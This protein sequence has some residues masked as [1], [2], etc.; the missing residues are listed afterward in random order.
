MTASEKNRLVIRGLSN[1]EVEYLKRKSLS[2]NLS[3]NQ[4]MIDKIRLLID[5]ENFKSA[6]HLYQ[7]FLEEQVKVNEVLLEKFDER[8]KS[9]NDIIERLSKMSDQISRWLEFEGATE[10]EVGL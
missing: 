9:N 1:E 8:L 6:G 4:Y 10:E 3:L 5:D 7:V 2:K